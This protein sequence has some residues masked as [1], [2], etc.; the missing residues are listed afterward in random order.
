MTADR[1]MDEDSHFGW[2]KCDSCTKSS[3]EDLSQNLKDRLKKALRGR[4]DSSNSQTSANSELYEKDFYD[5]D[6]SETDK[7]LNNNSGKFSFISL[8]TTL[9]LLYILVNG[10]CVKKVMVELCVMLTNI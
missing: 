10:F 8:I 4:R 5:D 6:W 1:K 3:T 7:A 2:A 9:K